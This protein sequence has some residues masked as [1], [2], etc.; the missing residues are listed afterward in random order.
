MS[1]IETIV[2]KLE[3]VYELHNIFKAII[4][5]NMDEIDILLDRLLK[6]D[7]PLYERMFF[8]HNDHIN[9]IDFDSDYSVVVIGRDNLSDYILKQAMIELIII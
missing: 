3:C 5:H 4:I 2:K 6:K 1:E 9:Q 8:Y 7:F